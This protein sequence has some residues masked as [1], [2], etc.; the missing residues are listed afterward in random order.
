MKKVLI[1]INELSDNPTS[2]EQDVLDQADLVAETL[3][4]LGYT[5]A[6]GRMGLNLQLA[7]RVIIESGADFVFNL[8]ES[9]D[10]K[11]ELVYLPPALLQSVRV[12]FSGSGADAMLLTSNKPLAKKFMRSHN[13]ATPGWFTSTEFL[14]G[15][16][17]GTFIV[18][19]LFEDASVGIDDSSVFDGSDHKA[20]SVYR[21]RFG[22]KF[23]VEEFIEGREFNISVIGASSGPVVLPPAEII[24]TDFPDSKPNIVGYKAKWDADSFEFNNTPRT[25]DFDKSD[26]ELIENLKEIT[27]SCWNL[28]DLK[29]YARV[30]FRV[31]KS[32]DPYVL[33]IN[34]NP[35]ISPDSGF[36]AA[37]Q[38]AGYKF[39]E[40]VD[41]ILNDCVE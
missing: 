16:H 22:D 30:D 20:I 13:I 25:F 28:F 21:E 11:A 34:A 10:N 38:K 24:F 32:G 9:I 31:S 12:P 3:E 18:K 6:R 1:L 29:G 33:E 40:I 36:Y 27:A 7:K 17:K 4:L 41:M 2:D 39:T 26:S 37:T 8:V 14:K 23:F 19:P 15:D 5:T 35:C